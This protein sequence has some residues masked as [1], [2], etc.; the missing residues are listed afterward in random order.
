MEAAAISKNCQEPG[1][2]GE[3]PV[4]QQE[5]EAL[6]VPPALLDLKRGLRGVEWVNLGRGRP[7]NLMVWVHWVVYNMP[8]DTKSLPENAGKAR[9]PQGALLGLNDCKKTGYGGPCPP[10]D[11]HRYFHKLYALDITLDLRNAT[12]L[13]IERAMRDHVLANAELIGTYQKGD[14]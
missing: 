11:R 1:R 5:N 6:E 4:R 12:K 14:R 7:E 2:G 8:P 13:Q 9:L 10:I 3:W